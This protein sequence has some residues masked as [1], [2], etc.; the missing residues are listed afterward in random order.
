MIES[1]GV[2]VEDALTGLARQFTKIGDQPLEEL[3]DSLVRY[4]GTERERVDDVALL[5]LR[6]RAD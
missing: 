5:L 3:A 2:D 1:P 4:S 6:A